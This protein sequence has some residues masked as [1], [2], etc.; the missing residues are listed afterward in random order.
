MSPTLLE[1]LRAATGGDREIDARLH[2]AMKPALQNY[3]TV[4]DWLRTDTSTSGIV[5]HYTA[6]LSAAVALVEAKLPDATWNCGIQPK[7]YKAEA[8]IYGP[9]KPWPESTRYEYGHHAKAP[10]PALAL[11]CAFVEAIGEK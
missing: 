10:T 5:P 3:G 6:D 9:I 7:P 1:K 8:T 4:D 11:L 2:Y